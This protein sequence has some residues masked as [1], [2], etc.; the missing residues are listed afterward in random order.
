MSGKKFQTI[1]AF[2]NVTH[3]QSIENGTNNMLVI[4]FT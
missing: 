4:T 3:D 2:A 1:A